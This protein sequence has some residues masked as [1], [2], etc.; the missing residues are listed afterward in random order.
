MKKKKIS[1]NK[2]LL[3][4]FMVLP[5]YQDS[6]LS[7]YLGAAG[8]TVLMPLSL[9]SIVVYCFYEKKLP[10]NLYLKKI[11]FLGLWMI[12]I[13][14][15]AIVGWKLMGNPMVIV[16]EYLPTKALKV[17]LQFFS[18]P[19]YIA[20]IVILGR[21]CGTYYIGKYST[22][23]L[24]LL[25]ILCLVE[26]TQVPY[27][28]QQFHYAGV[29]PYW[30]CRLLTLESSWTAMMI[31]VYS[32][33]AIYWGIR[34]DKKVLRI[35]DCICIIVLIYYTGS[36]TL[37]VSVAI[38]VSAYVIVA[39]KHLNKKSIIILI[40]AAIVMVVFTYTIYPRLVS[41]LEN[42]I[43][44]FTSVATRL[45]TCS[46]GL[47]IGIRYPFGVGG[48]VY[49]G[50]LKENLSSYLPI[51]NDFSMSFNTS[52]IMHL[53]NQKTDEALSVKSGILQNNM[54]WGIL[55][56]IYLFGIFFR[57]I[58]SVGASKIYKKEFLMA[59]FLSSVILLFTLNFSFEFWLF[60]SF[61]VCLE[62]ENRL[63]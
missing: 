50:V 57:L 38:T 42:D 58:K 8:Y 10:Y 25:T 20:I 36:K 60:F 19:S 4:L 13:S 27:S 37:M 9:I 56:T 45:Y 54:Y 55:G 22:V 3:L 23:I 30:R 1:L 51:L 63:K 32:V 7:Q 48:G 43:K 41:G 26:M 11:V 6:P 49:L 35:I 61:L 2:I 47:L 21:K 39:M 31:Y 5:I 62:E 15:I 46:I 14:I 53:I 34:F 40:F 44:E 29:F 12:I 59:T 28:F 24:F 16:S 33:L 18:F 52:E 17:C